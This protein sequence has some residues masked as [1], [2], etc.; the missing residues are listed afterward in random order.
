M[1]QRRYDLSGGLENPFT[2]ISAIRVR[3]GHSDYTHTEFEP[4]GAAGTTFDQDA[5]EFRLA[6]DH[7]PIASWPGGLYKH[8][9][10]AS[11]ASRTLS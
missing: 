9:A 11:E 6:F 3:A 10:K 1:E 5:D 7:A 4:D 2:G 8:S